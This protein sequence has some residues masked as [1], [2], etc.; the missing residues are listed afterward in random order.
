MRS[1]EIARM[2]TTDAEGLRLSEL[3]RAVLAGELGDDELE[4]RV[5]GYAAA[6]RLEPI[7]CDLLLLSP[8]PA[9]SQDAD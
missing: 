8:S 4:A 7:V 5:R 6:H 3:L 9:P 1:F 2:E